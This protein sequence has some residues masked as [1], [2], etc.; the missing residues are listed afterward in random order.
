MRT[1]EAHLVRKF[2]DDAILNI[3]NGGLE[4]ENSN[5][6]NRTLPNAPTDLYELC[7]NKCF[8]EELCARMKVFLHFA[9][10]SDGGSVQP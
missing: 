5:H 7:V 4:Q 9:H 3:Y 2:K 6:G 10:V 8:Y 1:F